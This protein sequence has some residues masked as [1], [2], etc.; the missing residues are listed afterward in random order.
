MQAIRGAGHRQTDNAQRSVEQSL[1][2][3]SGLLAKSWIGVE[4]AHQHFVWRIAPVRHLG[5][6]APLSALI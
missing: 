5:Q 6:S 3:P 1:D 2:P 4:Q